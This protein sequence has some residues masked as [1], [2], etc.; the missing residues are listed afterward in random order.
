MKKQPFVTAIP[1][2]LTLAALFVLMGFLNMRDAIVSKS[3]WA[4][5]ADSPPPTL[6]AIDPT[7]APNDLD[8]LIVITGTGFTV[9]LSGTIVLTAP[10]V[11][12]GD[13]LLAQAGWVSTAT[14][15]ATV[16]W[17]MDTGVY[18]L[19]VINPD[20]GSASL[21]NAFTVTQGIGQ[22]NGGELYGGTGKQILF[23][24]GDPNTMYALGYD[25]GLF[26]SHDAGEHW[27]FTAA[28]VIGNADFVLDPHH[29]SWLYSARSGLYRSQDE[30]GSWALLFDTWPDGR[31]IGD[32]QV[33]VS[34]HT[35]G[36]LFFSAGVGSYSPTALGLITSDDD[37]ATWQVIADLEG[38][39]VTDLDFHPTDPLKMALVTDD[40]RVFQS[41]DGGSHWSQVASSP[42]IA[43]LELITYNPYNPGEVWVAADY[44]AGLKGVRKSTD[45][46][47]WQDVTPV[48][49]PAI[50][51]IKFI[52]ANTV[53]MAENWGNGYKSEDGGLNWQPF[54]GEWFATTVCCDFA[55]H[56]NDAQIIYAGDTMYGVQKS[57]DGGQTWEIKNQG[58]TAMY[59]SEIDASPSFPQR[60]YAVL[61]WNGIFRSNDGASSWTFLP[62]QNSWNVRGVRE[63]PFDPQRIYVAADPAFYISENGGLDW[64]AV[65]WGNGMPY[66]MEPDPYQPGR[67]LAG[68]RFG[69]NVYTHQGKL[70]AS[71]DYGLIWQPITVTQ[72]VT[73]SWI[74]DIAYHP[75]VPGLV[76][77][78][79]DGSGLYR[80]VNGGDTWER[81]DDQNQPAM[82]HVSGIGIATHPRPMLIVQTRGWPYRSFDG[83]ATWEAVETP[84]GG[85]KDRFVFVDNDSTRLYA[86][87]WSGLFFSADGGQTWT[88]AAGALGRLHITALDTA[89][90]GNRAI[91]YA[92]TTG[93]D[94][95]TGRGMTFD[96]TLPSLTAESNLVKAGIYRYVQQTW[97]TFL[98]LVQR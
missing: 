49:N 59:A 79:T 64:T 88:P 42:Q 67:L 9:E 85:D 96:I 48:S 54:G 94:A 40:G 86:A 35:P 87:T 18:T 34:P 14:L 89:I 23:K 80:S 3:A 70:F 38:V 43:D 95:G 13:T 62:I 60:V 20:G 74:V 98:P 93:G 63:D 28:N 84:H 8:T 30:S 55:I 56:P 33:Y 65:P 25:V 24:P 4:K 44:L 81:I 61:G 32:A 26:R 2:L 51:S 11:Y 16:P 92:A 83:G 1:I 78:S 6:I 46:S 45:F 73:M 53:L 21:A 19:T 12:L 17:G 50:S 29:P 36:R 52:T 91:L 75:E 58:F 68:F 15:T 66:A 41:T 27:E 77:L 47:S 22:W 76:Y 31:A 39:P 37:G 71:D 72:A 90:S 57:T 97:Q 5:A 7:S 82:Q 10:T 69:D